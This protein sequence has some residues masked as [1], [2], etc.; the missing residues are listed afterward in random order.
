VLVEEHLFRRESGRLVTALTRIFGL[1]N[2]ALAEDVTQDV[3]CRALEIWKL[4]GVPQNPSAWLLKA[5]KNRAIDVLRREKRTVSLTSEL[6]ERLDSEWTLVPTINDCFAAETINDDQLRMMFSCCDPA[7]SEQTQVSLILSLLCGFGVREIAS[8]F[9]N[10]RWAVQ[11]RI[12]RGKS[13][14]AS[15]KTLFDM[16]ASELPDRLSSVHRALYLLFNEG[17][18]GACAQAAVRSE[19]C[20]EAMRLTLLL[21]EDFRT[22]S[23]VTNA[24]YALMCLNAA[25]LPARVDSSGELIALYEQDRSLWNRELIAQGNLFLDRSAEGSD[26]SDYHLEAAIA[27]AHSNSMRI[28]ETD[29]AKIVWLYD[30]L[31]T[32]RPSPIVALNRAIALAQ[33]EGPHRGI[34]AIYAI[35][36]RDRLESYPF[37]PA[38]LGELELRAGNATSARKH[39]SDAAALARNPMERRFLEQRM[40]AATI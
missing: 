35:A 3:F 30:M 1:K 12:E 15:S 18:H 20:R 39:F 38:A 36:D 10:K 7:L 33:K 37:F 21:L 27:A 32:I 11:K 19:L 25:R 26:L 6:G 29:W 31:A 2:L 16:G 40:N 5:A 9:L 13:A 34:E 23:A 8:A 4:R 24:L 17:Y 28:E 22:S 14:L